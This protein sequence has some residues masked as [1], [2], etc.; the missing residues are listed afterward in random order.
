MG[1]SSGSDILLFKHFRSTWPKLHHQPQDTSPL[2]DAPTDVLQFLRTTMDAKHS[3]ED[4]L[5]L[6][7]LAAKMV[8]LPVVSSLRRPGAL[9]RARWMAKALYALK[10]LFRGNEEASHLTGRQLQGLQLFNRFV[11]L[12]YIQS[13]YSCRIAVDA[14]FNDIT[15]IH[16]LQEYNDVELSR[17][18]LRM[19]VRHSWYHSPEL[20]PLALLSKH[21][22]NE[23]KGQLV[24]GEQ[25]DR[26]S[27]V[28]TNLFWFS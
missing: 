18:G 26:G 20:A 2:I 22:L 16:Q 13:W 19:M 4:Y 12:V 8:G 17:V 23:L 27:H 25:Q 9:T 15:L 5:E 3:R 7:H 6:I 28:L 10:I 11:V 21:V 24:A 1:P 14:A